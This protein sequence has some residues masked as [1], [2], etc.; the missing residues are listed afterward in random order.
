MTALVVNQT[1]H[2]SHLRSHTITMTT[3]PAVQLAM[4]CHMLAM[5]CHFV[6][7]DVSQGPLKTAQC[8]MPTLHQPNRTLRKISLM[9]LYGLE[10]QVWQICDA[11]YVMQSTVSS[12]CTLGCQQQIMA[13]DPTW[14]RRCTSCGTAVYGA[15][16][17]LLRHCRHIQL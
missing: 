17:R 3:L 13:M 6:G 15:C 2:A 16:T 10:S 7:R 4:L 9:R 12:R 8:C 1:R 5:A 11:S 14:R